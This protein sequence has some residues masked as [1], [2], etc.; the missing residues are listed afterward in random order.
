MTLNSQYGCPTECPRASSDGA[1][2]YN[3]GVCAYDG[4]EDGKTLDGLSGRVS[5]LC[6]EPWGG[7]SCKSVLDYASPQARRRHGGVGDPWL[8]AAAC[9]V[10][11][12]RSFSRVL[13]GGSNARVRPPRAE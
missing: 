7:T 5:C 6:E 9:F 10:G 4:V 13:G 8:L 3:R 12:V 2:C 1:V 11:L